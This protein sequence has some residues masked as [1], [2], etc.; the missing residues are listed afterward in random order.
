MDEKGLSR[1]DVMAAGAGVVAVSSLGLS[2]NAATNG[3]PAMKNV[4]PF[5]IDVPKA[6]LDYL[7]SRLKDAEW[8]DVPDVTDPWRYG[9][10]NAALKDLVDYAVTKYDWRA[11]EAAM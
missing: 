4:T 9:T 11:R 7:H 6:R 10:S 2:A 5:K 8:P 3:E 1:R